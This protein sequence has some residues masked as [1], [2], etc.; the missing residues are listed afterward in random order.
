METLVIA[1]L[2]GGFAYLQKQKKESLSHSLSQQQYSQQQYQLQE[3]QQQQYKQ[4]NPDIVRQQYIITTQTKNEELPSN[5][6]PMYGSS[7]TGPS[8]DENRVQLLNRMVGSS[9]QFGKEYDTKKEVTNMFPDISQNP[10]LSMGLVYGAPHKYKEYTQQYYENLAQEQFHIKQNERPFEQIRVGPGLGLNENIQAAGGFDQ[11]VRVLPIYEMYSDNERDM[12]KPLNVVPGMEMS[13][14]DNLEYGPDYYGEVTHNPKDLSYAR[15]G[16]AAGFGG[17]EASMKKDAEWDIGCTMRGDA[18]TDV[19]GTAKKYVPQLNELS[20]PSDKNPFDIA[21]SNTTL[22]ITEADYAQ[23]RSNEYIQSGQPTSDVPQYNPYVVNSY[24]VNKEDVVTQVNDHQGFIG[25]E[26][27][28]DAPNSFR[29]GTTTQDLNMRN[30]V[31]E[32]PGKFVGNPA[33]EGQKIQ[34]LGT[35]DSNELEY[36]M[37]TQRGQQ[38]MEPANFT[39]ASG[40]DAIESRLP[41]SGYTRDAPQKS[42][43][44]QL[45]L[46]G[47]P[48]NVGVAIHNE[49]K[50]QKE[51]DVYT[52]SQRGDVVGG[53]DTMMLS[54]PAHSNDKWMGNA[55]QKW[56]NYDDDI[57]AEKLLVSTAERGPAQMGSHN[58]LNLPAERN[59][60]VN[61][62]TPDAVVNNVEDSIAMTRVFERMPQDVLSSGITNP[63]AFASRTNYDNASA[64]ANQYL[65][66]NSS[67]ANVQLQ[68]NPFNHDISA[69]PP[70]TK[71]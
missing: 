53:S 43:P 42:F 56:T 60:T 30:V 22:Y 21:T 35:Y 40:A 62:K 17:N 23:N 32:D 68:R 41:D 58:P 8:I 3:Y 31:V 4:T 24:I 18:Y 7:L 47:T 15:F 1:S 38:N 39:T 67:D 2:I 69:P 61:H 51:Q 27:S 9:N 48:G 50:I 16:I 20:Q 46:N 5:F 63:D 12:M 49:N 34:N 28:L 10:N 6:V 66:E 25:G 36:E 29:L 45:F 19:P 52:K 65:E 44:H 55:T 26:Q 33:S 14:K 64:F 13:M 59:M 37:I 70:A 11:G 54:G 71:K 57:A